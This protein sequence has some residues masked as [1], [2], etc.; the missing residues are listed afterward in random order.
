MRD[1]QFRTG[2]ILL[3]IAAL[4]ASAIVARSAPLMGSLMIVAGIVIFA[5]QPRPQ[6][7]VLHGVGATLY[8]V[9][10][11]VLVLQADASRVVLALIVALFLGFQGIFRIVTGTASDDPSRS[12]AIQGVIGLVLGAVTVAWAGQQLVVGLIFGMMTL[13]R[14]PAPGVRVIGLFIVIDMVFAAWPSFGRPTGVAAFQARR[15]ANS[16]HRR[17]S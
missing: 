13:Q 14:W 10:G 8:V 4:T 15:P 16:G 6:R 7:R 17:V 2:V 5:A 12:R 9:V 1:G 11:L 3:V